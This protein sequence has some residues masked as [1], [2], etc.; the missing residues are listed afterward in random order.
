MDTG[1]ETIGN[2]ILTLYDE[3]R[4]ILVTD[5]WFTDQ[6][7]FGSWGQS[8][9]FP[10][11]QL[12]GILGAEY[13]WISHGH[14]DHLNA[15]SMSQLKG[16]KFLLP[17]HV[18]KRIH[19]DLKSQGYDVRV[20]KDRQWYPLSRNVR[21]YC[22]SDLNQDAVLLA[23]VNGR[24][25]F[26]RTDASDHGWENH[27]RS[28]IKRYPVSFMM[29]LSSRFGDA[30]MINF[31]DEDGRRIPPTEVVPAIGKR[32][33]HR[34]ET[35]GAKYFIPFSSMHTYQREDSAWANVHHTSLEDYKVGF[36]SEKCRMLPAYIRYDCGNDTWEEIKPEQQ[37]VTILPASQFGDD[38]NEKLNQ[39]ELG[40]ATRYFQSIHHLSTHLDY[41][42][43]RVGG[44]DNVI[45][46]S[47]RKYNRGVTFEA[48]RNSLMTA[49]GYEVFDDMLIA[50]FMKT[51]LHGDWGPSRLYPDFT[52]YVAKYADNG[53]AKT[54][55]ELETY[56]K[57][58]RDRAVLDYLKWRFEKRAEGIYRKYVSDESFLHNSAKKAYWFYKKTMR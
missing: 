17:D 54:R 36:K 13:V 34:T 43:L 28:I 4:P 10:K 21:L 8:H 1:F 14:P 27:V 53:F 55:E 42:N 5:P 32:N 38:W 50:N 3:G 47:D 39:D 26:N 51:T 16:K 2:A 37:S 41:I 49:I 56:F 52:P 29:G 18:G 11:D 35:V 7:Y 46:I 6:A 58:Y 23:D 45:R 57:S 33:A 44:Q 22:I 9:E 19:D 31:F 25:I 20:M 12:K 15:D 30:D 24:L 40:L 48:P